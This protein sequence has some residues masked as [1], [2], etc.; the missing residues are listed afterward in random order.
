M[1]E[2]LSLNKGVCL[3]FVLTCRLFV[4][5]KTEKEKNNEILGKKEEEKNTTSYIYLLVSYLTMP[6]EG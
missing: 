2:F 4:G 6:S 5:L 1:T 3:N